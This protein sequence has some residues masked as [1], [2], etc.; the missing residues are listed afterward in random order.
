MEFTNKDGI[1]AVLNIADIIIENRDFLSEVDGAIGD[2]DHGVNMA[3]GFSISKDEISEKDLNMSEGFKVVSDVLMNKIG[4]S[5]GPLYGSFFR[6]LF[7]ASRKSEK[8]DKIVILS[9]LEKAYSNIS[10]ISDAKVNDKTLIDVLDPSIK[11]YKEAVENDKDL[12]TSLEIMIQAANE[13]VEATK[14]MVANIGR[15]ARLGER[16]VGHQDAG[17]TSC[18]LILNA[19]ANSV[20]KLVKE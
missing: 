10:M 11:S 2:G 14:S 15:A 12:I 5:M 20:I 4:G 13:G 18:A 17:A 19:F 1:V 3:K 7:I 6:G 8:I 9:M 16:S